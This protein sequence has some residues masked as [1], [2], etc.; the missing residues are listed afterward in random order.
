VGLKFAP[1]VQEFVSTLAPEPKKRIRAALEA[2]RQD[3]RASGLDIKVLRK[4]G[5]QRYFRVRVGEYRIVYA[6]RGA[7]TYVWRIMHRSEGYEW[8]ERLDP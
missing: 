3:P 4:D 6:P 2:I 5:A 7:H 8:F 1:G